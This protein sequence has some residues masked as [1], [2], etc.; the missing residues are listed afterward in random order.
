[1]TCSTVIIKLVD[2]SISEVHILV[3]FLDCMSPEDEGAT[4]LCNNGNISAN[5]CITCMETWIWIIFVPF[6]N[7]KI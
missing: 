6:C 2:S 1:L 4:V 7:A 5:D 3:T